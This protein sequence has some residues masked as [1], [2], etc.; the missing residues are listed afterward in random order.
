M[1]TAEEVTKSLVNAGIVK[2]L[3]GLE[4]ERQILRYFEEVRN[5]I[6]SDQN[7]IIGTVHYNACVQM[8]ENCISQWRI[9]RTNVT[10]PPHP[11]IDK[12]KKNGQ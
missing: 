3:D 8:I 2:A 7:D 6:L 10:F 9:D 1:R 4:C 12:I 5:Q 11:I